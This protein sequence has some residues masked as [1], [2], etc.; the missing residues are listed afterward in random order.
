MRTQM[1]GPFYGPWSWGPGPWWGGGWFWGAALIILGVYFLLSNLGLLNWL[2]G[3]IVWPILVI[4]LGVA[5]LFNRT[6]WSR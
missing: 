2:R 6:L 4:L 5:L 1:R 3:E